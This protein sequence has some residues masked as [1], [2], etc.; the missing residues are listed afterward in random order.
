MSPR[1]DLVAAPALPASSLAVLGAAVLGPGSGNCCGHDPSAPRLFR[2]PAEIPRPPVLRRAQERLAAYY[3]DPRGVLPTLAAVRGG[4]RKPRSEGRE[5]RVALAQVLIERCDLGT[6]R[7][8]HP[9]ATDGGE[10]RDYDIGTLAREA[11]ISPRRASRALLDWA[12]TGLII[13]W[14]TVIRDDTGRY[15]GRS[16]KIKLT[17]TLFAVLGLEQQF[18]RERKYKKK[19]KD[20]KEREESKAAGPAVAAMAAAI[21]VGNRKTGGAKDIQEPERPERRSQGTAINEHIA[22]MR[23]MPGMTSHHPPPPPG[24]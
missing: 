2:A 12:A 10:W 6:L 5:S 9:S 19:I 14:Y 11:G 21:V 20:K 8:G 7:V 18:D 15:I 16:T 24:A 1:P 3:D 17:R 23:A 22:T 4:R 13:V